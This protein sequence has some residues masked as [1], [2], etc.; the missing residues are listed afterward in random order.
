MI[1]DEPMASSPSIKAVNP[2]VGVRFRAEM[3]RNVRSNSTSM[4]MRRK[5]MRKRT[6]WLFIPLSPENNSSSLDKMEPARR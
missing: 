5:K 2:A 1:W 4:R 3:R 6:K